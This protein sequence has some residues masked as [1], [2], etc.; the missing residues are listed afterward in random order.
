MKREEFNTILE[1]V[2]AGLNP[3]GLKPVEYRVA[4]LSDFVEPTT[5]SGFIEKTDQ[6][7][8]QETWA[9][10]RGYV[11]AVS[12]MAFTDNEGKRWGCSLPKVGD[13]ILFAK[14]AG[15]LVDEDDVTYRMVS[16]K[17]V[18]AIINEG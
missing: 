4:I 14:Y 6:C 7:I 16:D 18:L 10:T 9:Q 5:A 11:V 1:K 2:K 3:S 17:D 12:D 13:K 8:E 15:Q